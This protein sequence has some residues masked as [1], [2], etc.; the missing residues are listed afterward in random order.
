MTR[1]LFVEDEPW[2]VNAYFP[3]LRRSHIICDLAESYQQAV[4]C[5]NKQ[6]YDFICLDIMFSSG[7]INRKPFEQREA[8]LKLLQDI[9]DGQIRNCAKDIKTIVLTAVPSHQIEEK[10]KNLNVLRYFKKPVSY[11]EVVGTFRHLA[12]S[13]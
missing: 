6:K 4:E 9:R 11:D 2:G 8:G 10:I 5:L 3:A 12:A 1:V 7:K 13:Y